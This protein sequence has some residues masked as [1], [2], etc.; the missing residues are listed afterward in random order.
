MGKFRHQWPWGRHCKLWYC[1]VVAECWFLSRSESTTSAKVLINAVKSCPYTSFFDT[2][3]KKKYSFR[4]I[5]TDQTGWTNSILDEWRSRARQGKQ[6]NKSLPRRADLERNGQACC[7]ES[8]VQ[9]S[10][11]PPRGQATEATAASEHYSMPGRGNGGRIY[12]LGVGALPEDAEGVHRREW[13]SEDREQRA[14]P[15][16][17]SEGDHCRCDVPAR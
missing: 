4:S 14:G 9:W 7:C 1:N 12:L 2:I 13:V 10:V 11:R 3:T 17:V 16:D 15:T 6:W 8:N 5:C